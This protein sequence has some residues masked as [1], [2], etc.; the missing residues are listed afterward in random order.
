MGNSA[1]RAETLIENWKPEALKA[2]HSRLI[3]ETL[4]EELK[5]EASDEEVD[6]EI[7]NMAVED[8]GFLEEYKKYYESEQMRK[9]LKEDIKERKFFD[10]LLEKST[11][12]FGE[13]ETY[14]NLA[15]RNR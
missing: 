9:Y 8:D 10:I 14:A 3:V 7:E 15:A 13:K 1:E 5:L 6:K 11:I 4:I 12:K 2:I